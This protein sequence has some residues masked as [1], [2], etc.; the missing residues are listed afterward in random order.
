MS[1]NIDWGQWLQETYD[2]MQASYVV[3]PNRFADFTT[4]ELALLDNLLFDRIKVCYHGLTRTL[5][6]Q[7]YQKR[8]VMLLR[9]QADLRAAT[10]RV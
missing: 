3:N 4:D 8:I 2:E 1:E 10:R 6:P 9:L 5:I 7:H